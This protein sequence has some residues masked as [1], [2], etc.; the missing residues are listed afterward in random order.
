MNIHYFHTQNGIYIALGF[1]ITL[2][3]PPNSN[4]L[5]LLPSILWFLL[6]LSS[7]YLSLSMKI[8]LFL[9]PR[10]LPEL[11]LETPLLL[12]VSNSVDF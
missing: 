4:S 11:A 6:F 2:K 1:P 12:N 8:I 7:P 5:F 10:E 3:M 9:I